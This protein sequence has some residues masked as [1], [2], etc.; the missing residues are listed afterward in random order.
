MFCYSN[1]RVNSCADSVLH[2]RVPP[3]GTNGHLLPSAESQIGQVTETLSY[4][5]ISNPSTL[6][7]RK[8]INIDTYNMFTE[9]YNKS[10]ILYKL[11]YVS[12]MSL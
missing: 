2:F 1:S 7:L 4:I 5:T 11:Q 3:A 8:Y 6:V 12:T 9:L 10:E